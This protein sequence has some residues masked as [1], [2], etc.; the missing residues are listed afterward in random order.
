M[1]QVSE[2]GAV[3]LNLTVTNTSLP[4]YLTVYPEGATKPTASNLNWMGGQTVPNRVVV[5]VNSSNGQITIYNANGQADVVV[6]VDGY[7][8][9]GST[10]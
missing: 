6:D 7:F 10:P 9:K 4:S 8:S 5:P 1:P 2:V 3:L